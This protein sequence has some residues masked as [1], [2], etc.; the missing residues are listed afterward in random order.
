MFEKRWTRG[1]LARRGAIPDTAAI[2]SDP[3]PWPV[4]DPVRA[5]VRA[6]EGRSTEDRTRSNQVVGSGSEGRGGGDLRSR[7]GFARCRVT[8]PRW[9]WVDPEALT[10]A[11]SARMR[12]PGSLEAH[13]RAIDGL[14]C[15]NSVPGRRRWSGGCRP[16]GRF[17]AIETPVAGKNG[18]AED[19]NARKKRSQEAGKSQRRRTTRRKHAKKR[20]LDKQEEDGKRASRAPAC[21]QGSRTPP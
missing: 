12:Q 13:A 7:S 20:H 6:Y 15:R 17:R 10:G 1:D 21:K 18:K 4:L 14:R 3:T 2:A 5:R 8:R 19:G 9:R 16:F 11:V